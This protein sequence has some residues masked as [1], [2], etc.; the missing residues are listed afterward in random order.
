[1]IFFAISKSHAYCL[2]KENILS[3]RLEQRGTQNSQLVI[4]FQIDACQKVIITFKKPA[5]QVFSINLFIF[6]H[7]NAANINEDVFC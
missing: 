7:R 5:T 6:R 2:F 4:F 3:L 1:M